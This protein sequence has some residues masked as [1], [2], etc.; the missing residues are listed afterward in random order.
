METQDAWGID[1]APPVADNGR[2][3]EHRPKE[4][5]SERTSTHASQTLQASL[6]EVGRLGPDYLVTDRGYAWAAAELLAYLH[7]HAPDLLGLQVS[8]RRPSPTHEGAIYR[9]G[10]HG[11]FVVLYRIEERRLTTSARL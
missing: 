5:S 2:L 4:G 3:E 1:T 11:G 10:A 6:E 9:L 7:E 8:L